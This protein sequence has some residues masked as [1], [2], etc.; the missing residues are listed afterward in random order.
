V[1]AKLIA[2]GDPVEGDAPRQLPSRLS[3]DTLGYVRRF[4]N[5]VMDIRPLDRGDIDEIVAGFD[6][7]GWNKPRS[8]F[9]RYLDE[10]RAGVRSVRVATIGGQIAGYLT[11]VWHSDYPPFRD[12]DIPEIVDL[13][14]YPRFRRRGVARAL[15]AAAERLAAVRSDTVGIGFGL[16]AE[17][18]PAQQLYVRSGY[19]PDGRGLMYNGAPVRYGNS[20]PVD[21]SATLMLTKR[22]IYASAP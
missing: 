13:N 10:Q 8:L 11:I 15:L 16:G 7:L 19:V 5:D 4:D 22:L 14:V 2:F 18:G 12:A 9:E 17:Y 3:Q 20:V 21:D 1:P 6:A